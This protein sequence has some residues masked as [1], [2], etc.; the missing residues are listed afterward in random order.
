MSS[1]LS[2]VGIGESAKDR[3]KR[4]KDE[5]LE[6]QR[7]RKKQSSA[8]KEASKLSVATKL[9]LL[10]TGAGGALGKA[11]IGRTKLLGN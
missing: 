9:A 11:D 8:Q 10:E 2:M 4:K 5:A 7:V 3:A 1:L 6:A